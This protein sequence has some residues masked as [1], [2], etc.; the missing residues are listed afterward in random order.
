MNIVVVTY[1]LRERSWFRLLALLALR[2]KSVT[3]D[4]P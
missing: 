3:T 4:L 2:I 1:I